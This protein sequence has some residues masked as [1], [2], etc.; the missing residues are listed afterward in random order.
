[1]Q[2]TKQRILHNAEQLFFEYGIANVR[3]QQIADK[4][5]ISVGNLAYHYSNKETIVEA[6]YEDLMEDVSDILVNS[7]IRT[8]LKSF[9]S[10]FF[11]LYQFMEKKGFYFINCWEIKR[12]YPAV[13]EKIGRVNNKIL[14]KLRKQIRDNVKSGFLKKEPY[15]GAHNLLACTLFLS[16]NT[17]MP[18]Q[19]LNEKRTTERDFKNFLWG[20]LYPHFSEKGIKEFNSL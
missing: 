17:W 15:K 3:L 1:M 4:T 16:I 7:N 6:V 11:N 18:Q 20:H 10:K 5:R 14:L 12:N 2:S 19:L 13:N 8:G 9:D